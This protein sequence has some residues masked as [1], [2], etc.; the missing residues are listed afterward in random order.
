MSNNTLRNRIKRLPHVSSRPMFGYECFS[1]NGKF[2]VGFSKKSKYEVILRLPKDE[3]QSAVR[4]KGIK[5][6][7][8]GA[9]SGWIEIDTKSVKPEDAFKWV[10]KAHAHAHRLSKQRRGRRRTQR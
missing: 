2:F 4:N 1:A 5:P 9:K 7:S 6:F 10:K 3:Q 8:H